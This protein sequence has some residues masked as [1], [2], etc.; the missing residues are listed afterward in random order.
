MVGEIRSLSDE[1]ADIWLTFRSRGGHSELT[2]VARL[3]K[4]FTI[5]PGVSNKIRRTIKYL[6][7]NTIHVTLIVFSPWRIL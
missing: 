5:F 6:T 3:A 7:V 1:N 4:K 2:K